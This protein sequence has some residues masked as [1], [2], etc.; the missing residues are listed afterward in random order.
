MDRAAT[1]LPWLLVATPQ[2]TDPNFRKAVVLVV[3]HDDNGTLGFIIN[4]PSRTPLVELLTGVQAAVPAAVPA[5]YGGPAGKRQG[6]ILHA[7]DEAGHA[8]DE[9]APVALSS[10]EEALSSLARYAHW[11]LGAEGE[12][13]VD[14]AAALGSTGMAEGGS[15]LYPYRFL[16]GYAG[17]GPGQLMDELHAGAWIQLPATT[18]LVFQT[19]W[20]T[21]WDA[22]MTGVGINPRTLAPSPHTYLN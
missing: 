12:A 7:Q 22:A 14:T 4:R 10:S 3:E 15:L 18:R 1:S 8:L 11:R 13:E 21:L 19:D 9:T 6:I 5:W 2:L 16:V 17:W 20:T